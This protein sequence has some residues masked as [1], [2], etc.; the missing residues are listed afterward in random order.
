MRLDYTLLGKR[1]AKARKAK[2]LT[3]EKLAEQTGL[4]NNYISNI[5]NNRS[6]PSLET[7]IKLCEALAI[8]PNDLLLGVSVASDTY[9]YHEIE[10]KIRLCTPKE[11]RLIEE[12]IAL[13]LQQRDEKRGL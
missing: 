9:M 12:I 1:L 11:R 7:L 2:G 5:E 10:E 4:A 3:Q 6:I 13:I 8:T